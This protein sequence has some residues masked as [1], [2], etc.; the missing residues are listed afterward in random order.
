MPIYFGQKDLSNKNNNFES[1][2]V[3][4]LIGKRLDDISLQIKEKCIEIKDI[5][6]SFNKLENFISE[7]EDVL[8]NIKNFN[9][10]ISK[11]EEEG[12]NEKLKKQTNYEHDILF[13]N[14]YNEKLISFHREL[15]E[16]LQKYSNFFENISLS[17]DEN[18]DI[19]DKQKSIMNQY[20]EEYN[21]IKQIS[22]GLKILY[23]N[24]CDNQNDLKNKNEELKEEFAKIKRE[25]NVSSIDPDD[26]IKLKTKLEEN[27]NRLSEIFESEKK[28]D[29]IIA[30]LND[31]ILELNNLWHEEF[32]IIN[33]EVKKINENEHNL[34]ILVDYKG[35]KDLLIE[36]MKTDFKGSGI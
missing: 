35:R 7:K 30:L 11:Y 21:R 16:I 20:Q 31:R 6:D 17:S 24:F 5:I 4:K 10:R 8:E 14:T 3:K 23:K 18:K 29:S 12:L 27:N 2:L 22:L 26:Y 28:R 34:D 25:I 15:E 19:F 13:L 1:D 9:H 36:K 33:N 32:Q